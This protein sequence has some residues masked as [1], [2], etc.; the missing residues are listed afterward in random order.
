MARGNK[1]Q[2][3]RHK[4]EKRRVKRSPKPKTNK[5]KIAKEYSYMSSGLSYM[6]TKVLY[7]LHSEFICGFGHPYHTFMWYNCY[8]Y[9][10]RKETPCGHCKDSKERG[11]YPYSQWH[12]RHPNKIPENE[13]HDWS[14]WPSKIKQ[15]KAKKEWKKEASMKRM[16]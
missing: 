7:E 8:D 9:D 2:R 10:N 11:H 1:L 4:K 16:F 3:K 14:R 12:Q 13:L 6:K 15:S 5:I